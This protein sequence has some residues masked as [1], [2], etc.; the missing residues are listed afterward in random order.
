MF[1]YFLSPYR[2]FLF[3]FHFFFF[4]FSLFPS[5]FTLFPFDPFYIR[6]CFYFSLGKA[7]QINFYTSFYHL[8]ASV[9]SNVFS[10]HLCFYFHFFSIFS[11]LSH[12]W[13]FL[14]FA[15]ITLNQCESKCLRGNFYLWWYFIAMRCCS[16]V[17]FQ[18]FI[19]RLCAGP[20]A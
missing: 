3:L 6:F 17:P 20:T 14:L 2:N 12:F 19:Y 8:C 4:N 13:I 9:S 11:L 15:S 10:S 5:L 1:I 16:P 18:G 7:F